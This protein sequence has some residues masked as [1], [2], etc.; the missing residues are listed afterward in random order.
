MSS[1]YLTP[2]SKHDKAQAEQ[3]GVVKRLRNLLDHYERPEMAVDDLEVLSLQLRLA[4][5]NLIKCARELSE[6]EE[7]RKTLLREME[8]QQRHYE[9]EIDDDERGML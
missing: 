2:E 3:R 8:K 5:V 7:E 4:G 6:V 1:L 9:P